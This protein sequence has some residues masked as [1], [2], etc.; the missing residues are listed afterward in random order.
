MDL[1]LHLF[2]NTTSKKVFQK[3]R[4]WSFEKFLTETRIEPGRI[5]SL[6]LTY[7][8]STFIVSKKVDTFKIQTSWKYPFKEI[9]ILKCN[10]TTSS[11][12]ICHIPLEFSSSYQS[13][14]SKSLLLCIYFFAS[15]CTT[16]QNFLIA[17]VPKC[18]A[19]CFWKTCF[20][21]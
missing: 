20:L 2:L 9:C 5:S 10:L 7:L 11:S 4:L 14:I 13:E 18:M 15:T 8:D 3:Y 1:H 12:G 19:S 21:L 6:V 17:I 16:T